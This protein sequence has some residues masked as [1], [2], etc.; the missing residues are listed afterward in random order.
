MSGLASLHRALAKLRAQ[1][2]VDLTALAEGLALFVAGAS[3]DDA[4]GLPVGWRT[5]LRRQRRN[6][7]LLQLAHQ[8]PEKSLR[9]R[10]GAIDIALIRYFTTAWPADRRAGRRPEGRKGAL[11]DFLCANGEPLDQETI[12]HLIG[13]VGGAN[14]TVALTHSDSEARGIRSP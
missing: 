4:L 9:A 14:G 8:F 7:A 3:V 2:D 5:A 12:R 13:G 6:A 11:Y 1:N 10:A